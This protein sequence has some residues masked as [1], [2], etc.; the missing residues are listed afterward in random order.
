MIIKCLAVRAVFRISLIPRN[1]FS[2]AIFL[3]RQKQCLLLY[4]NA[5]TSYLLSIHLLLKLMAG[6]LEKNN[7]KILIIDSIPYTDTLNL[8]TEAFKSTEF[9]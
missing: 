3:L 5:I 2:N 7:F 4:S 1:Y 8:E 9:E 6:L